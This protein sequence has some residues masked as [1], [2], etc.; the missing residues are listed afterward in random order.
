ME[1]N[2]GRWWNNNCGSLIRYLRILDL[3][4]SPLI[5]EGCVQLRTDTTGC[6][7]LVGLHL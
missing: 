7:P 6:G 1:M 5:I 4:D 3:K 2:N